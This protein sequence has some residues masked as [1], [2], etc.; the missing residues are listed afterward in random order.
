LRK[1]SG[2]HGLNDTQQTLHIGAVGEA[3]FSIRRKHF[4]LSTNCRQFNS[5]FEF[6]ALFHFEPIIAWIGTFSQR[7]NNIYYRKNTIL[8]LTQ[9][10]KN[11]PENVPFF[12]L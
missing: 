4:Q 2:L 1:V 7:F 10:G 8:L 6:D 9:L 11:Y 12:A 5:I 3:H